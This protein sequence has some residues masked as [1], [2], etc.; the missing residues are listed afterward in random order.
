MQQLAN[1]TGAQTFQSTKESQSSHLS[2]QPLLPMNDGVLAQNHPLDS[3]LG[4]QQF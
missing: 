2:T 4:L 1:L 3:N